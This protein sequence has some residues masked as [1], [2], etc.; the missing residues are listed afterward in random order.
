MVAPVV[1]IT[2][3]GLL[4]NGLLALY[5]E[6]NQRLR[7]MSRER[8]SILSGDQGELLEAP[9]CPPSAASG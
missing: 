2:T 8:V 7:E 9:V 4:T 6:I 1:L 5:G 3:G